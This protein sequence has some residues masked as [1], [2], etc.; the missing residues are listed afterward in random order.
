MS[1]GGFNLLLMFMQ[2]RSDIIILH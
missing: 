1:S 2:L